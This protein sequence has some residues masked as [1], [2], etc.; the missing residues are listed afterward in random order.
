MRYIYIYNDI[1]IDIYIY[2]Y[3]MIYIYICLLMFIYLYITIYITINIYIYISMFHAM[4]MTTVVQSS[5]SPLPTLWTSTEFLWPPASC[6]VFCAAMYSFRRVVFAIK[7]FSTC[8]MV[9]HHLE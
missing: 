4:N 9:Q 2:I 8:H 6:A 7:R 1:Y 5:F 3:I